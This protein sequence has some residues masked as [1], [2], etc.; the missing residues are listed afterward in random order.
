MRRF[1]W[2]LILGISIF[3]LILVSGYTVVAWA[4]LNIAGLAGAEVGTNPSF[5]PFEYTQFLIENVVGSW[6]FLVALATIA[7]ALLSVV[8]MILGRRRAK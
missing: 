2:G 1:P 3:A 7:L 6:I 5:Q 4:L 8:M